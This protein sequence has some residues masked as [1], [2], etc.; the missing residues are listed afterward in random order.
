MA[1]GERPKWTGGEQMEPPLCSW[2]GRVASVCAL[3]GPLWAAKSWEQISLLIDDQQLA[4]A[5]N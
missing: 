5:C 4:A 3:L 1:N 2:A